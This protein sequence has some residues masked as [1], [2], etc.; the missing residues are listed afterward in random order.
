[1]TRSLATRPRGAKGRRNVATKMLVKSKVTR[2]HPL[3]WILEPA[4][5][6]LSFFQRPTFGCQAVYLFGRLVFVLAAKEEPWNGLLV[7]TSRDYHAA[8]IGE[9]PSLQPHPVLGKWL[10]LAQCDDTFEETSRELVLRAAKD[11]RRIGVEP[12]ARKRKKS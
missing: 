6:E 12:T 1:M 9:F 2:Q 5:A 4:E 7:C 11:D 8:L 10:Y 3:Q